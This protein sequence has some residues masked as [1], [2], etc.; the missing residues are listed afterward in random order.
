[1]IFKLE[2]FPDFKCQLISKTQNIWL[3]RIYSK[4]PKI[5]IRFTGAIKLKSIIVIG[6]EGGSSPSKMRV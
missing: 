5:S 3:K 6:G 2:E 1:M 4:L